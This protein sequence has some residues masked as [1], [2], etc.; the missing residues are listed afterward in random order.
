L[1]CGCFRSEQHSAAMSRHGHTRH[2]KQSRTWRSWKSMMQR[3]Y[4]K[5]APDYPRYGGRGICVCDRWHAFEDFLAD[6]GERHLGRTLDRFP[7]NNGNYEPKN[8]RW[9]TLVEQAN[10]TRGNVVVIFNGNAV[11][12][13]QLART[14]DMNVCTLWDRIQRRGWSVEEATS[15]PVRKLRSRAG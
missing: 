8:C 10:H 5:T 9:A 11:T 2:G 7:D 13:S 3:C 12:I 14:I 15:R 4:L 6:M 1:S